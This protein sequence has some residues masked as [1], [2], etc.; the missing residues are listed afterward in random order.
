MASIVFEQKLLFASGAHL[1]WCIRYLRP[2]LHFLF[3][4]LHIKFVGVKFKTFIYY[5][6]F[7]YYFIILFIY[8]FIFLAQKKQTEKILVFFSVLLSVF[9]SFCCAWRLMKRER[10]IPNVY[11]SLFIY[12][13][14]LVY[15]FHSAAPDVWRKE[16]V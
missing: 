7:I 12:L 14:C 3:D 1:H 16:N 8:L 13:F 2:L 10:G 4:S 6:L 9:F 11:L 5:Y 15:F